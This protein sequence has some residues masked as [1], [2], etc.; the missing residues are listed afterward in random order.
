M[1][2]IGGDL[3]HP[4]YPLILKILIQTVSTAAISAAVSP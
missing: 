3:P 1:S 2:G 4:A